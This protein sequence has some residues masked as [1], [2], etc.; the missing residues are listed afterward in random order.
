MAVLTMLFALTAAVCSGVLA[1]L[2]LRAGKTLPGRE[3]PDPAGTPEAWETEEESRIQEGI[4][5]LLAYQAGGG[6]KEER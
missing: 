6:R 1:V 3:E 5:N 2:A 4:A